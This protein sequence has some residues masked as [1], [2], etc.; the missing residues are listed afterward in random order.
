M[1]DH[2]DAEMVRN[3][4]LSQEEDDDEPIRAEDILLVPSKRGHQLLVSGLGMSYENDLDQEI[5]RDLAKQVRTTQDI[6]R[7]SFS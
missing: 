4:L 6:S 7:Q 2:S 5:D 1:S 3:E